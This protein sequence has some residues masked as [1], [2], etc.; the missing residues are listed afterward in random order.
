M[1]ISMEASNLIQSTRSLAAELPERIRSA[2]QNAD[3]QRVGEPAGA[4]AVGRTEPASET[5][6]VG[7]ELRAELEGIVGEVIAGERS[8][9][10]ELLG[11]VVELI[12]DRH[13]KEGGADG[14][15]SY[16][17]EIC[18]RM[19][20]DPAVVAEIDDILQSIAAELATSTGQR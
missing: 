9:P 5:E 10:S 14:G 4:E 19:C 1:K 6:G 3:Q 13:L 16:R 17:S 18:D 11:E 20:T 7:A 15:E 2:H 8:D 12:V